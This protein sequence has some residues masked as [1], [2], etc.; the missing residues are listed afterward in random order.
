MKAISIRQPWAWLILTQGKDIEN[1]NWPTKFRGR[2]A[3][4]ASKTMDY[5]GVAFAIERG[6]IFR[7]NPRELPRGGVVG[8][9]EIVDCVIASDSQ[10]FFGPY[11][12]LLRKPKPCGLIPCLGKLGVFELGHHHSITETID[13]LQIEGK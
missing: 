2:I 3:I 12:F 11:G 8:T 10:W 7:C 5:D 1:R 6:V 9:V 13:K 4:H